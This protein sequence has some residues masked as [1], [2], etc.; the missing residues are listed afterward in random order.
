M[1][2]GSSIWVKKSLIFPGKFPKISIFSVNFTQEI[3]FFRQFH[4][5]FIFSRQKL[6]IY[7]YFWANYSTSLQ[8]SLLS[9]ILPVHDKIIIAYYFTSRPDPHD[10]P[11]T[12]SLKSWGRDTPNSQD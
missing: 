1:L 8:K 6:L 10:P 5:Q 12:S 4:K 7:S 11:A 2:S 9:N 3:R